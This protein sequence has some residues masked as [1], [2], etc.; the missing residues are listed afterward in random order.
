MVCTTCPLPVSTTCSDWVPWPALVTTSQRPS[1]EAT[2]FSGRSPSLACFPAG[3]TRNPTGVTPVP[4]AR[5]PATFHGPAAVTPAPASTPTIT[6]AATA[7]R[8]P[9][10]F[11]SAPSQVRTALPVKV[12]WGCIAAQPVV[13]ASRADQTDQAVCL[14]VDAGA[15]PQTVG[16]AGVRGAGLE[17]PQPVDRDRFV[18]RVAELPA[19]V[20][21]VRAEDVD[22]AVTEVADQQ[23][24]GEPSEARRG[25]GQ[26]PWGVQRAVARD[27]VCNQPERVKPVNEAKSLPGDLVLAGGVLL[28]VRNVDHIVQ[29]R[30]V[31]RRVALRQEAV[32]EEHVGQRDVL[33]LL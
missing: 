18:R 10:M 8:L 21:G 23:V 7:T 12:T 13:S 29:R 15:E 5:G 24:A 31:E 2:A 3:V 19:E 4:S 32:V 16:A 11:P 27:P 6:N 33:E 30:H 17:I 14:V 9:I 22:P 26:T 25:D 1:G 28:G 20:A